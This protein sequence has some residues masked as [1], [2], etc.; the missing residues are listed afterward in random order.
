MTS[1]H[2]TDCQKSHAAAFATYVE[3]P[4]GSFAF[5]QG[6]GDLI[7]HI[8]DSGTRRQFCRFCS[9]ILL[10]FTESDTEWVYPTAAT[11]DTRLE[12]RH[13]YHIFVRSKAPWHDILD[14][15]PQHQAYPEKQK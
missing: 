5:L 7:T 2:C 15:K 4:R 10:S 14:G 3:V 11:L 9:S 12:S 1:C 6:E 13:D 8:A